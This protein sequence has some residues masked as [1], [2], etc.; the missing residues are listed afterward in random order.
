M[1]IETPHISRTKGGT[2]TRPV[3]HQ[4]SD[5]EDDE[6]IQGS[7]TSFEIA[8]HDRTVLEEEDEREK[9][10]AGGGA[11][12]GLRRIFSISNTSKVM[13]GKG[14]RR[15][16]KRERRKTARRERRRNKGLGGGEERDLMFEMEEGR[17]TGD[18]SSESSSDIDGEKLRHFVAPGVSTAASVQ[19]YYAY[20]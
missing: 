8:E 9:L 1:A 7:R 15:K 20:C 2:S 13:V 19:V 12:D 18:T 6:V 5:S 10:L 11:G 3:P 14:E 4:D 16:R 17:T